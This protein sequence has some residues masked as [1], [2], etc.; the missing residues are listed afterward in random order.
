MSRFQ[1][2]ILAAALAVLASTELAA[3]PRTRSVEEVCRKTPWVFTAEQ[4]VSKPQRMWLVY[5]DGPTATYYL[6]RW[7]GDDRSS[8]RPDRGTIRVIHAAGR[9][10]AR[11]KIK[12]PLTE[13]IIYVRTRGA[14]LLEW[15]G[16]RKG[17][18]AKGEFGP[19]A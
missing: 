16:A 9:S 15:E 8:R 18:V 10:S 4:N 12:Q 7:L 14:L 19:C 5:G 1:S 2:C 17:D 13:Q 3:A 11:I 6:K